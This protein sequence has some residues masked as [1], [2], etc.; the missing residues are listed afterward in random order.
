MTRGAQGRQPPGLESDE[1]QVSFRHGLLTVQI[2][3]SEA[4]GARVRKTPVA[5]GTGGGGTAQTEGGQVAT[6][7]RRATGA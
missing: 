2:F 5:A 7:G 6:A 1:A 3:K 4:A